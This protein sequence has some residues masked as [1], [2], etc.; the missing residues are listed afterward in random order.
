MPLSVFHHP[1]CQAHENAPGHIESPNRYRAIDTMLAAKKDILTHEAPRATRSQLSRVH[2]ASHVERISAHIA[3]GGGPLDA[4]TGTNEHSWEASIRAAGAVVAA[5]DRAVTDHTHVF[6]AIRPPGHHAM[7]D[8]PMGFCLFNNIAVGVEHALN[9][10]EI[11]RVGIFDFDV[12]HGNG[13]EAIFYDR[14]DI[15]FTSIHEA[16]WYP[17]TGRVTDTGSGAGV[18]T[19]LN[20]PLAAGADDASLLDLWLE[21]VRPAWEAFEPEIIFLSAG[22][23]GDQRD[24]LANLNYT[25]GGFER[26]TS[27]IVQWSK[28]AGN[29][30]IISVLEGGY[31]CEAL[32]E[33]VSVHL[34]A[35][36]Q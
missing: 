31:N 18:G 1:S 13:T 7:P 27:H 6:C 10:L 5:V 22:F 14:A 36:N 19:T 24:P 26:L 35:L 25:P 16:P 4:D 23:D 8:H 11:S 17:G 21:H 30:N 28:A 32:A 2:T 15:H 20:L 33:D 3:D 29:L 34:D 9:T 12:H